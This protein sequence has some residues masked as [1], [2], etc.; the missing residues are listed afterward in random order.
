MKWIVAWLVALVFALAPAMATEP[1]ALKGV[2]LVIGQ[3]KYQHLPA[4]ANP[5]SDAQ[6]IAKLFTDLGFT[7]TATADRNAKKLR[8]DLENFASDAEG[9]DVAVV[10]YS[11]HGIEAGGENWLVPVDADV[12]SLETAEMSLVPLSEFM[13]DL[14]ATVPVT[15]LFLDACRSNPFPP[16]ALLK[17]DGRAE[18]VAASGLAP[19]RGASPAEARG[20]DTGLGAV[21][22]FAA[23]P[24]KAALD[25]PAGGNSPYA[26]A[27]LRHLSAMTGLEFGTVMRM[28]TEE[29]YLKTQGAQRPWINETLTRL[30]YFGGKGEVE[31]GDDARLTDGRRQLLLT[32]SALPQD[33]RQSVERLARDGGLPLAPL[34]GMLKQLQVN[35]AAGPEDIDRQLRAG[36]ENLK[37]L[38]AERD[39]ITRSDPE[40]IRLTELGD[41]AQAEGTIALAL[42]YRAQA[43]ARAKDVSKALKTTE[44]ELKARHLEVAATFAKEAET[45]LLGFEHAKAADN[46]ALAFAEVENWDRAAAWD[47]MRLEGNA[48]AERG[49]LNG[50]EVALRKSAEI[51]RDGLKRF[52]RD[53][54]A[55]RWAKITSNLAGTLVSLGEN[56]ATA[57]DLVEAAALYRSALPV[58]NRDSDPVGWATIQNNLGN[59]LR[60][61][62]QMQAGRERLLES[63]AALRAALAAI[64]PEQAPQLWTGVLNNIGSTLVEVGRRQK[65]AAVTRQA[66]DA[67]HRAALTTSLE[68]D[69]NIWLMTRINL[70]NGLI[71]L[72][73]LSG[74]PKLYD[75]AV[76]TL[77][78]ALLQV[79]K[80]HFPVNWAAINNNLSTVLL[81]IARN[82]NDRIIL[83]EARR[84][85]LAALEVWTRERLPRNWAIAQGNLGDVL[86][87]I[88]ESEPRQQPAR[89]SQTSFRPVGRGDHPRRNP[90]RPAAGL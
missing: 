57:G 81:V 52:P 18:P 6:A 10:Y 5:A 48:W 68:S 24:G 58:M 67:L 9:A 7:V 75:E 41:R 72:G 90:H 28:V 77:K 85:S 64:T 65:D 56:T 60:A 21:L 89:P 22:G 79:N 36:A 62:G 82:R 66:I 84:T 29:V 27:L 53:D 51:Y 20:A 69:P 63:A 1:A 47:Y 50:D 78:S 13:D 11:G 59:A 25:G 26:A 76:T 71:Q 15:L 3:S 40:I 61:I 73:D 80:E 8:R 17:K 88:G 45:A 49:D 39:T 14:K 37:K 46:Y 19:T 87:A 86:Q 44:T 74:D 33:T 4:L 55:Q 43:S 35:T 32:I 12:G 34:Y 54:D 30:L 31:S 42:D 2:A 38:L 83:D 16:G 70:G 23:E